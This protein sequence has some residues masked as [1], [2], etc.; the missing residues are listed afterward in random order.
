MCENTTT[1]SVNYTHQL[2]SYYGVFYA[3]NHCETILEILKDSPI[4]A[5]LADDDAEVTINKIVIISSVNSDKPGES[6]WGFIA[7]DETTIEGP[8]F[9]D[10]S[11]TSINLDPRKIL[12]SEQ[13][14]IQGLNIITDIH[15]YIIKKLKAKGLKLKDFDLYLGWKTVSC[16]WESESES[17]STPPVKQKT[18]KKV[19]TPKNSKKST[20]SPLPPTDP[21]EIVGP[22]L[23]VSQAVTRKPRTVKK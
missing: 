14:N 21:A 19:R 15:D 11:S 16:T 5:P 2:N 13:E 12:A 22:A 7:L 1:E 18:P 23:N 10:P 8:V 20:E 3:A 9:S 17:E 4:Y 6:Q